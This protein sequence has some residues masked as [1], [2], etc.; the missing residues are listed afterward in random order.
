MRSIVSQIATAADGFRTSLFGSDKILTLLRR[1]PAG[2]FDEAL[3]LMDLPKVMASMRSLDLGMRQEAL[4][5]LLRERIDELSNETLAQVIAA[6]H[7]GPTPR[8]SQEA[9]VEVMTSRTGEDYTN[10]KYL[11]NSTG[12]Q[13]DLEHLVFEDLGKD[14]RRRLLAH[15]REQA[16]A[17]QGAML[18][19]LCDIDDTVKCMLHD[20]RYPRGIVYPGVVALLDRLD[21]GGAAKPDTAGD[22]TFITA[23]P[24]GPRGLV[25][26]YTYVAMD[27]FGLPPYAV[28]GGSF[29]NL[30][31]K[32]AISSRKLQ[33]VERDQLL[34]PETQ[35]VFLG[36]SGQADAQVGQ[37]MYRRFGEHMVGTLLHNVTDLG[38]AER[39]RLAEDLVFVFD[40]Y[41]GAAA[42]AVRLNLI[43]G[44]E[45]REVAADVE[46]GLQAL[47]LD[48][49]QRARLEADLTRDRERIEAEIAAGG[50]NVTYGEPSA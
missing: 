6:L 16:V 35:M 29:L 43:T 18:R 50:G 1:I 2:R 44:E 38:E 12:D 21:R 23:R 9:I 13:H 11:L 8:R 20:K 40:T 42:H 26:Q 19:I 4:D 30:H 22:L 17:G 31:T 49:E 33:N 46:L 3:R 45:A 28:Q 39:E 5:L 27:D 14:L 36:D 15:T 47:D 37:E 32:A 7:R 24:G 48:A 34:F 41:A 25:S 10:L